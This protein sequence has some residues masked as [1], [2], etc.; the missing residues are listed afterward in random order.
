MTLLIHRANI[1]NYSKDE[2][3][4]DVVLKALKKNKR[5]K[6]AVC[7]GDQNFGPRNFCPGLSVRA[8]KSSKFRPGPKSHRNF[9]PGRKVI[10]ISHWAEKSSE[11]RPGPKSHRNFDPGRKVTGI[12]DRDESPGQK[13]LGPKFM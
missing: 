2:I 7:K 5:K 4:I 3:M 12:S 11:F 10:G 1:Y 8:E 6:S 13:F 9:A